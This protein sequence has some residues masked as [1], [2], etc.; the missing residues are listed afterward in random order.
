MCAGIPLQLRYLTE[1]TTMSSFTSGLMSVAQIMS[2]VVSTDV[3]L[4]VRGQATLTIKLASVTFNLLPNLDFVLGSVNL[5]LFV[6]SQYDSGVFLSADCTPAVVN[7]LRL[8]LNV[9]I[10]VLRWFNVNVDFALDLLA[11][12]N[13]ATTA[14]GYMKS[15]AQPFA[16]AIQSETSWGVRISLVTHIIQLDQHSSDLINCQIW[17]ATATDADLPLVYTFTLILIHAFSIFSS[18]VTM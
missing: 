2:A 12:I 1:M 4:I 6:N 17:K 8:I 14:D 3:A 5:A 10:K 7:T 9:A 15:G 11:A 13:A 18:C 16:I